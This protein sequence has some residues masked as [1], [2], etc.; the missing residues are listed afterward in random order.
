MMPVVRG[1]RETRKQILIYTIELVLLTL[2]LPILGLGG[3]IYFVGATL[4]GLW[5][6][7]AAWR[8]WK[9]G[10][11]KVA[12]K[13]YRYSSMYLAFLFFALMIDALI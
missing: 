11:N 3:G 10:G 4:L 5:L 13:M 9:M 7:H 1:E 2:A 8:V 12:W 6:V